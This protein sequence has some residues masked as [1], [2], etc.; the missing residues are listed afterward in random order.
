MA[1][2]VEVHVVPPSAPDEGPLRRTYPVVAL[3]GIIPMPGMPMPLAIG[4]P[5]SLAA[6][7][8]ARER[9]SEVL[10]LMQR[11]PQREDLDIAGLYDVG[12]VARLS[13]AVRTAE[14]SVTL[15]AQASDRARVLELRQNDT[16]YEADVEIVRPESPTGDVEIDALVQTARSLVR[17][18]V[19]AT[20]GGNNELA[21]FV[22]T[23][24]D[25]GILADVVSF[26]LQ[27]SA[28]ER[29]LNLETFDVKLRLQEV[30]Q[31]AGHAL[32]VA[33]LGQ[34]IQQEVQGQLEEARRQAYLR[35]QL[36]AIRKEMGEDDDPDVT[37]IR[38]EIA[39]GVL[40]P[41][42][43]EAA[44]RELHRLEGM[45][46]ASPERGWIVN[47]LDWLVALP[48]TN[49]HALREDLDEAAEIL[50]REHYG[51]EKA[52]ERILETL[53]VR[54]RNPE[55]R[56]PILCFVGPPGT[57]KTSLAQAVAE[58][59]GRELVRIS[60]GG[61]SDESEI[62]GHRRTYVGAMPGRIIAAL[63]KTASR[64][65][66]FVVDEIDKM[67]AS[68]HGDPA[69][70]LLEVLD[71]E[72]NATFVDRYI[73]IPFDLSKVLFITTAN[74]LATLPRPL[75]DRLEVI[76][77][78]GYTREEKI[79]I[80]HRHLVPRQRKAIG[81]ASREVRL[82]KRTLAAIIEGWTREAGVRNLERSI[83]TIMRKL[84][85]E[86]ARGGKGPWTIRP[87]DLPRYLGPHRHFRE[88]AER[89]RVP[90]VAM[91][92][93]WTP[94]GGE[95]LFIEAA[96]L[97]GDGR[98]QLTGS[99]GDVMKESAVAALTWLRSHDLVPEEEGRSSFHVHVPAGAV[100][101]DGPSAGV[102]I[103]VALASAITGRLVRSDLAMT[104]EISLRG[105]VLPVGGIRD[106]V[107]GAARAGVKQ[108]I[109]PKRNL[110]DLDEVPDEVRKKIR[111][112]P[113]E[114]IDEVLDLALTHRHA[115][116]E[117]VP[118]KRAK[119]K[120]KRPPKK[121]G[122]RPHAAQASPAGSPRR[123]ARGRDE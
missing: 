1:S 38:K 41:E 44:E 42:A 58:A 37:R 32:D 56:A 53:A 31:Q 20:P 30:V 5:F 115:S 50:D 71:P 54:M 18:I 10:L 108:I 74:T 86:A 63:R 121:P 116:L 43:R 107:L 46:S 52:K 13:K 72:Q 79:E 55:G 28:A 40:G 97:P 17:Q 66:V 11:E 22:D 3:R 77:V 67:S 36:K 14:S 94:V 62:R 89:M 26:H 84:A 4:R 60:V 64:N 113:V 6:V 70:A 16:Y 35:E 111:F 45:S 69:A 103:V 59:T 90:G 91:G 23:V 93:A 106:K 96:R 105:Q 78:P 102:T 29:Q 24:E 119:A 95:I 92:L 76:E 88:A 49:L 57:G 101:K 87:E 99:L 98:L 110:V 12:V 104:G 61:V 81:M 48:W 21:A 2:E 33:Q 7:G 114:R 122:K 118:A 82:S 123:A 47:Y 73:E 75:L 25:P 83:G 112:H 120:K 80:A 9:E 8:A 19:E 27:L 51:M 65:P 15:V 34:K 117:T 39:K 109:L 100:P 68:F 85:L